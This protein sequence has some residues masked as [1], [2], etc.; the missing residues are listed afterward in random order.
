MHTYM[1]TLER[2]CLLEVGPAHLSGALQDGLD[3]PRAQYGG[4]LRLELRR[5]R[6]SLWLEVRC[7]EHA[8]PYSLALALART[9]RLTFRLPLRLTVRLTLR[10]TLR[11]TLCLTLSLPPQAWSLSLVPRLAPKPGPKPTYDVIPGTFR[12]ARSMRQRAQR[13][14]TTYYLLLTQKR[15][16]ERARCLRERNDVVRWRE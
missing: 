11:L 4:Y 12:R 10:V 16:E 15:S 7:P 14:L 9:L 6:P 5:L 13:L 2:G 3:S 8:Q 1:H